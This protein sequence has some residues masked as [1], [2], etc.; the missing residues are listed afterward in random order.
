LEYKKK[1][2]LGK[3]KKLNFYLYCK[4][5]KFLKLTLG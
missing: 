3:K 4:Y 1:L 2:F 5:I